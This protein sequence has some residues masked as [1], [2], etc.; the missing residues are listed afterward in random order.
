MS[1]HKRRGEQP[2]QRPISTVESIR[3]LYNLTAIIL[4]NQCDKRSTCVNRE[5]CA[6]YSDKPPNCPVCKEVMDKGPSGFFCTPCLV[7]D[8]KKKKLEELG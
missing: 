1:K 3:R 4:C 6:M 2:P 7:K 8:A 5:R